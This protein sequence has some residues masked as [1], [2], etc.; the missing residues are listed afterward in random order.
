MR[1][2]FWYKLPHH[3]QEHNISRALV[4]TQAHIG[5]GVD[6]QFR[7]HVMNLIQLTRKDQYDLTHTCIRDT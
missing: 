3:P 6:T 1:I 2:K 4:H 5:K 7:S